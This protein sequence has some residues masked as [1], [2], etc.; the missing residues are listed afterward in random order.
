MYA[1]HRRSS[2]GNLIGGKRF[3]AAGRGLANIDRQAEPLTAYKPHTTRPASSLGP[4]TGA[5]AACD[6]RD[7]KTAA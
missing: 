2:G 4:S 1:A 7:A 3:L 5:M 6:I